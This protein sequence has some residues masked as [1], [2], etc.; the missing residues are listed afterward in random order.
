MQLIFDGGIIESLFAN[1]LSRA[2]HVSSDVNAIVDPNL[3]LIDLRLDCR[4]E[5]FWQLGVHRR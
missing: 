2:Y 5:I 3:S 1:Q 4:V